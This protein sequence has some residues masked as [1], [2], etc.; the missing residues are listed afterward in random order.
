MYAR[1]RSPCALADPLLRDAD[2]AD[3]ATP[4][5]YRYYQEQFS[6]YSR[7]P[8]VGRWEWTPSRPPTD[9]WSPAST[10]L[11][12]HGF[13][14]VMQG[15]GLADLAELNK[16][17]IGLLDVYKPRPRQPNAGSSPD[18]RNAFQDRDVCYDASGIDNHC[19][20]EHASCYKELV[21]S[22]D[23]YGKAIV[24]AA[25]RVA[26]LEA[27]QFVLDLLGL[28]PGFGIVFDLINAA[29]YAMCVRGRVMVVVWWVGLQVGPHASTPCLHPHAPP[30]PRHGSR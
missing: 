19:L 21:E 18:Q 29:L 17:N 1:S 13:W 6:P 15:I 9:N 12:R 23:A 26:A 16:M 8:P 22:Y 27:L 3:G 10:S 24:R 14:R 4:I 7:G 28:I 20:C 30:Q 5:W 11:V 25:S 2:A